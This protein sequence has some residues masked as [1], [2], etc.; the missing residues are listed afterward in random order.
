MNVFFKVKDQRI[1]IKIHIP[2][3]CPIILDLKTLSL[4]DE[5]LKRPTSNPG[6]QVRI[7]S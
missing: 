1:L 7:L 5:W 6:A 2:F 4:V 3:I